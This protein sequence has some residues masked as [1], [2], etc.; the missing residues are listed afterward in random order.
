MIGK[1]LL[2]VLLCSTVGAQDNLIKNG[3]FDDTTKS[4]AWTFTSNGAQ[5]TGKIEDS[6]FI[7][8]ITSPGSKESAPQLMQQGISLTESESYTLSFN[9]SANDAGYIV[10]EYHTLLGQALLKQ[11]KLQD[12]ARF[13][14]QSLS[15]SAIN[16]HE[17]C[18]GMAAIYKKLNEPEKAAMFLE[19]AEKT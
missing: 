15:L 7:I 19:M 1:L 18:N 14:M 16:N 6:K 8:A 2:I 17:S 4:T 12:A 13:F 10:V 3:N 11:Q 5:A 9:V